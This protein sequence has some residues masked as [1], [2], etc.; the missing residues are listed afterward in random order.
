M[1]TPDTLPTDDPQLARA[2]ARLGMVL[3]DK[4][5]LDAL[6]GVGGM[7]AVYAATHRNG[8][9]VAVKVLHAEMSQ[10]DEVKQRFLQEGYAAN[11]IQHEGAVSVL[12]DDVAADGSA[13]IVMELL[14]GET[15]ER[16][17]ERSGQR[18]PAREVLAIV[19]QLL[20][21][22]AAAHAKN[23][24]HRDVKPENLFITQVGQLKVLDFGIAKV[25]EAQR[26]RATTTRA[27]V[28]MGT[29]AFMAPEQARARWDEVDG[30]TDLWAVG[31]TMFTLLT[32][33]HVHEGVSG[34]EQLILSATAPAPS[35]GSVEPDLPPALVALV[36]RALAFDR[37]RRWVDASSMQRAVGAALA[38]LG[39]PDLAAPSSTRRPATSTVLSSGITASRVATHPGAAT[40][41]DTTGT[42]SALLAW[43]KEREQRVAEGARLRA[44]IAELSQRYVASKKRVAEA[45]TTLEAA[46]GERASLGNWLERQVG[47]RTAAVEEARK[48]TRGKMVVLARQALADRATFG[49][50]LDPPRDQVGRLERAAA[51]AARDVDV[52]AAAL[53]AHDP[54]AMRQGVLLMGVAAALLLAL[55]VIPIVWR[56]TR[57]VEAPRP[58]PVQSA[59]ASPR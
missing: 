1:T 35:L 36:D 33:R 51:A 53:D 15:V 13:F 21:V 4:W 20:D 23:V 42:A 57:V 11:T 45:E 54:R 12:D 39:G 31:A 58:L 25:F 8:K 26:G 30:R 24:V 34:N 32:G 27:G 19:E 29:P 28:V 41:I 40:L 18:L 46:R 59:P 55:L 3:E 52:H 43:T 7:A 37:A 17:W 44:S 47:T 48:Q 50:D 2:H 9:R 49:A 5:T 10:N 56:A 16:R 6:L 22:L 14:E 38:E